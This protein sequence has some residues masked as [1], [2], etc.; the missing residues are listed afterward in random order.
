MTAEEKISVLLV[1]DHKVVRRGLRTFLS[2]Y[3]DIEVVGEAESGVAAVEFVERLAPDVVLM[4]LVMPGM[5]GVEATRHVRETGLQTRVIVL[6]SFGND[7]KVFPALKAGALSYL[8]K[9]VEPEEL[10]GA[11]RAARRGKASIHPQVATRLVREVS[12]PSSR[13]DSPLDRLTDREREVLSLVAQG[14][15][16]AA[17]ARHLFIG[18][19]TVKTHVSSVLRKLRLEDRTQAALLALRE[20]LVPLD[21]RPPTR[22]EGGSP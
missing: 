10:V 18:E 5:D 21:D 13:A 20:R 9:D 17:I 3:P 22:R 4:D 14:M 2:T 1:D 11:V 7:D 19:R 6:T 12:S 8:L 16:N 15:G